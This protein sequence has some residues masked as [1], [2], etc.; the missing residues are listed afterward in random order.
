MYPTGNPDNPMSATERVCARESRWCRHRTHCSYRSATVV[1]HRNC[2]KGIDGGISSSFAAEDLRG[3]NAPKARRVRT[4]WRPEM[5]S[6]VRY[7]RKTATIGKMCRRPAAGSANRYDASCE[8]TVE[9][10]HLAVKQ[11]NRRVYR[12]EPV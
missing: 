2:R 9:W 5:S 12:G 6:T 10:R 7:A 1:L 11:R 8:C 4:S 3:S